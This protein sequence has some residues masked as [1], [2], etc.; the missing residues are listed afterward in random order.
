MRSISDAGC[1]VLLLAMALPTEAATFTVGNDLL[2]CTHRRLEDAVAAAAA[3]GPASDLIRINT[4]YS[5]NNTMLSIVNHSVRMVGG[6]SSCRS[7][8]ATSLSTLSARFGQRVLTIAGAGSRAIQ[9]HVENLEIRNGAPSDVGGG[10]AVFGN[11]VVSLRGS[12]IYNNEADRGGGIYVDGMNM[13]AS[14]QLII[15]A[16]RVD[17][18]FASLQGAGIYCQGGGR[19]T[20]R[21]AS[22]VNDNGASGNVALVAAGGGGYLNDCNWYQSGSSLSRNRARLNGGGLMASAGAQVL[23]D[24]GDA[25]AGPTRPQLRSNRVGSGR[26]GAIAATDSGTRVELFGALLASNG[27][28]RGAAIWV[29]DGAYASMQ[30]DPFCSGRADGCSELLM[31][32]ADDGFLASIVLVSDN[33][34][35]AIHQTLVS[36][37]TAGPGERPG[38]IFMIDNLGSGQGSRL[39]LHST[40]IADNWARSLITLDG[41]HTIFKASEHVDAQFLTTRGN[42]IESVLDA[43]PRDTSEISLRASI[44]GDAVPLHAYEAGPA[45]SYDC[46]LSVVPLG[47]PATRSLVANPLINDE[48]VPQTGSPALDYCS[49]QG[50]LLDQGDLRN[51]ARVVNL[52]S[53]PNRYGSLDLGAIEQP[54]E[55]LP[56]LTK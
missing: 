37:N 39:T 47:T 45:D 24:W 38:S 44:I 13:A 11:P 46:L 33:S 32:T 42:L 3:N 52:I 50:L 2:S 12:R 54:S 19:I 55:P 30:G 40:V 9:V 8:T 4:Y 20:L 29:G 27:G 21:S 36:R 49:G 25:L 1:V 7:A 26:G 41:S 34:T 16:S 23:I 51:S 35:A 17:G 43:L 31:N 53:V 56:T 48:Y 10:I 28:G 6:H 18:N 14:A 22:S 15:E 5:G